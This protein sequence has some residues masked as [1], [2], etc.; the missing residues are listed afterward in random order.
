MNTVLAHLTDT[1]QSGTDVIHI[2]ATDS[3]GNTAVRDVGVQVSPSS[4]SSGSGPTSGG[5]PATS[6]A[7]AAGILVVGGVQGS[8]VIPGN[9]DIGARRHLR[10]LLAA[11]TP[12]AYS[13]ASLT[14]GGTLEMLSGG[15]TYFTGS[16]SAGAVT[17]DTAARSPATAP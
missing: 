8:T 12:S 14:I 13:T 7:A 10:T 16:L 11:L 2:V 1:L 4:A 17:I 6:A 15:A 5:P 3:S 9:L